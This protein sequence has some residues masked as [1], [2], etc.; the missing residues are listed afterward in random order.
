MY[1]FSTFYE[2]NNYSKTMEGECA[3]R[4]NGL[5]YQVRNFKNGILQSELQYNYGTTILNSSYQRIDKDSIISEAKF[6]DAH[7][8]LKTHTIYYWNSEGRRC[9]KE[10]EYLQDKVRSIVSYAC[11]KAE[12]VFQAGY[13][14]A[15]QHTIDSEGYASSM[16]P[17]GVDIFFDEQGNL[18]STQSHEFVVTDRYDYYYKTGEFKS[19]YKNGLVQETGHFLKGN[20][21][22]KWT[23]YFSSGVISD[24]QEYQ[25]GAESG[26]WLGYHENGTLKYER[27][28]DSSKFY[29]GF[30]YAREWS[31]SGLLLSEKQMDLS[32]KGYERNYYPN[33]KL[34]VSI[35]YTVGPSEVTEK[36]E[37][38]DNG[39]LKQKTYWRAKN[40]TIAAAYD[41]T[42]L[43]LLLNLSKRLPSGG[44][45]QHMEYYF[46]N[47][48]LKQISDVESANN[49]TTQNVKMYYPNG[50]L[51][52]ELDLKNKVNSSFEYYMTGMLKSEKHY[53]DG[54]LNGLWQEGDSLGNIWKSCEYKDGFRTQSCRVVEKQNHRLK[55]GKYSKEHFDA[56]LSGYYQSYYSSEEL[57]IP[58]Q[59]IEA[60]ADKLYILEAYIKE[61][62]F[63][64]KIPENLS[65]LEVPATYSIYLDHNEFKEKGNAILQ[66][67]KAKN[68]QIA[69]YP[70]ENSSDF[71]IKFSSEVFYTRKGMLDAFENI[72]DSVDGRIVFLGEWNMIQLDMDKWNQGS[73]IKVER[74][75][76][77]LVDLFTVLLT[78]YSTVTFA[79][80][81]DGYIEM[82][83]GISC[84]GDLKSVQQ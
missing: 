42:G 60:Q 29:Y 2:S 9:V 49:E 46:D 48:V 74:K 36:K 57:F 56:L 27:I 35:Q 18:L 10:M 47:G 81:D 64:L 19:F 82:F 4:S 80:Y 83:N 43:L 50:S 53:K 6:M 24:D 5:D 41:S 68:W 79:V 28:Y 52:K 54:N 31:E 13:S 8:Q 45:A 22:G 63:D 7:G 1:F 75:E 40:D 37:F 62:G 44:Y 38:F 72:F 26:H 66:V 61:H 33:G 16:V 39:Q 15:P 84:W 34:K 67:I 25:Y 23:K 55:K 65:R 71:E 32:G 11:L 59:K 17:I 12:E 14:M 70:D 30:P 51:Y 73:D 77:Y 76:E 78:D 58:K 69:S 3:F 21:H 20:K